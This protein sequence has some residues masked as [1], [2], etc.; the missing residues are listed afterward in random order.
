MSVAL[1]ILGASDHECTSNFAVSFGN[2]S[3]KAQILYL[4]QNLFAAELGVL[5]VITTVITIIFICD[6]DRCCST[7]SVI[8]CKLSL[9]ETSS[10]WNRPFSSNKAVGCLYYTVQYIIIQP[11][12][13]LL[14]R[15]FTG[16][17]RRAEKK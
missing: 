12:E 16:I 10:R 13:L 9:P 11:S 1:S 4:L 3:N 8:F 15:E 2:T 6:R 14:Q 17:S 5:Q 7:Q